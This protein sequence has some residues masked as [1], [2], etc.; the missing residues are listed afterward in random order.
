M[1]PQSS[2]KF[3]ICPTSLE[4]GKLYASTLSTLSG[5]N[6]R[7][8]S[9]VDIPVPKT[10]LVPAGRVT[11]IRLGIRAV[12]L[13]YVPGKGSSLGSEEPWGY[14]LHARSSISKTPIGLAN[15]VG[16]IDAGYRGELIAAVRNY[17]G[18]DFTV[19]KGHALFQLTSADLA[20][21][22][23]EILDSQD[24]RVDKY[25]GKNATERGGDGFGSTGS[26]GSSQK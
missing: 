1:T 17:S 20:P 15:S 6:S 8:D 7:G 2:P 4:T 14:Y 21:V 23:F 25:F 3:I 5:K 11:K 19:K 12:C 26:G 9:G 18:A 16:I 22:E 13:R 10:T 24:S